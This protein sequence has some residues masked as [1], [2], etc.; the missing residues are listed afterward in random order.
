M[1]VKPNR[2]C[3]MD[4][5]WVKI[6]HICRQL[7]QTAWWWH[8]SSWWMMFS[9]FSVTLCSKPTETT[10]FTVELSTVW[11]KRHLKA[12][13]LLVLDVKF[14]AKDFHSRHIVSLLLWKH[15]V[16]SSSCSDWIIEL[17]FDLRL[18][19][20]SLLS[21]PFPSLLFLLCWSSSEKSFAWRTAGTV[22]YNHVSLLFWKDKPAASDCK[23]QVLKESVS[24][25]SI[26]NVLF[27]RKRFPD[28]ENYFSL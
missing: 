15:P 16:I 12:L 27:Y 8:L 7:C 25:V 26:L 17:W 22:I 4:Y 21:P 18:S 11:M 1:H 13:N 28:A 24:V 19:L 20:L 23:S 5:I 2:W 14:V 6:L 10:E 9:L 3:C